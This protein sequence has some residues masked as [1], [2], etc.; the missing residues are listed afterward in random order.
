MRIA[1]CLLALIAGSSCVAPSSDRAPFTTIILTDSPYQSVHEVW[2]QRGYFIGSSWHLG[3]GLFVTCAH[4]VEGLERIYVNGEPAELL[5][6]DRDR[7]VAVLRSKPTG[8]GFRVRGPRLGERAQARGFTGFGYEA[9][10]YRMQTTGTISSLNYAGTTGYDGGIHPGM[11]GCP[12][13]AEDGRV[14]GMVAAAPRW[15]YGVNPTMGMLSTIE[16][17][18]IILRD[19]SLDSPAI[20]IPQ[21]SSL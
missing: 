11:S 20:P 13:I 17:L 15:Q 7:D 6:Y 14:I 9:G 18:S 10:G 21:S 4:V 8:L 5:A 16:S 2:D 12:V 19:I 1:L 3:E